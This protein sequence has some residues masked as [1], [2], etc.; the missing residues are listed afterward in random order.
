MAIQSTTSSTIN[1]LMSEN[2]ELELQYNHVAEVAASSEREEETLTKECESLTDQN[3]A[4]S[5]QL[6]ELSVSNN[7]HA[8]R[9]TQLQT[10]VTKYDCINV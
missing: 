1:R 7:N 3:V 2:R 9:C 4:L 10:V 8:S 6:D 5:K